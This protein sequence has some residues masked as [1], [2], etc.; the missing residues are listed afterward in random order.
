MTDTPTQRCPTCGHP[1]ASI[2]DHIHIDCAHDMTAGQ[3]AR[4]L[5]DAGADMVTEPITLLVL[6]QAAQAQ[7]ASRHWLHEAGVTDAMVAAAEQR[8]EVITS[9]PGL[10]DSVIL[11]ADGAQR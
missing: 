10:F 1:V 2:F 8:G 4:L 11:T 9:G 3:I 5:H 7:M 6:L